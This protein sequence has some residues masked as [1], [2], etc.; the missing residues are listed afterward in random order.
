MHE[1]YSEEIQQ[2]LDIALPRLANG[3]STQRGSL[4]GFGPEADDDTGTLLKICSVDDEQERMKLN[5][6]C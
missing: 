3:F 4:F 6:S 1:E 5:K 2:L